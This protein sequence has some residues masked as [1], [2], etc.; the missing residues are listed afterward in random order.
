MKKR[1]KIEIGALGSTLLIDG[2]TYL[3]TG[4]MLDCHP[5]PWAQPGVMSRHDISTPG[6]AAFASSTALAARAG[7]R[8]L[9]IAERQLRQGAASSRDFH[10]RLECAAAKSKVPLTASALAASEAPQGEIWCRPVAHR[11]FG[12]PRRCVAANLCGMMR[13]GPLETLELLAN[14]DEPRMYYPL[15]AGSLHGLSWRPRGARRPW[16]CKAPGVGGAGRACAARVR[17]P[18][19]QGR[20]R[21]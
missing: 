2:Q 21:A 17:P 15:I 18:S 9:P 11:G 4:N 13:H 7:G 14:L 20:T 5:L 10:R 8:L 3:C 19:T 16:R 6:A 1:I 12:N